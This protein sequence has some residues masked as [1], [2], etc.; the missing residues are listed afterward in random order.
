MRSRLLGLS[1]RHLCRSH[2]A[3]SISEQAAPLQLNNLHAFG[4]GAEAIEPHPFDRLRA[5]FSQADDS[6]VKI[7]II[8][9]STT[10]VTYD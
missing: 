10:T 9:S 2:P 4:C 3:G 1:A 6:I 8:V 5:D 7:S